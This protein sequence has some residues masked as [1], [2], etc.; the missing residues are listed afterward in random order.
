VQDNGIGF[1]EKYSMRIFD[2]FQRL[3]ERDKYEGSGIGLSICRKIVERHGGRISA[4]STPGSGATFTVMLSVHQFNSTNENQESE[5]APCHA[6]EA[7]S[8]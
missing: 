5:E 4:H 3:H 6:E 1:E 7:F 8:C 2:V